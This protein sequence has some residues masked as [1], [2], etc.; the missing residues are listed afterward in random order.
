L[1]SALQAA[2]LL[3]LRQLL[4]LTHDFVDLLVLP[5]PLPFPLPAPLPTS[6]STAAPAEP[7]SPSPLRTT[8]DEPSELDRYGYELVSH[9]ISWAVERSEEE[10]KDEYGSGGLEGVEASEDLIEWVTNLNQTVRL[11]SLSPDCLFE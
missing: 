1:R 6:T 2:N 10:V 4:Q 5:I 7:V 3:N 11:G 8:A 9:Y